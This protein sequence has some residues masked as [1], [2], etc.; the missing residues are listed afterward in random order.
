MER[1]QTLT[2]CIKHVYKV[3]NKETGARENILDP[4]ATQYPLF[5]LSERKQLLSNS[6]V[7]RHTA[8]SPCHSG[9]A[10]REDK[11]SFFW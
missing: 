11:G 1:F 5:R 4:K 9:R 10:T 2:K 3:T 7:W 8:R 6:R